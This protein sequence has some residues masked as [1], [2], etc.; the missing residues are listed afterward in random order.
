M[1][2]IGLPVDTWLPIEP[3]ICDGGFFPFSQHVRKKGFHDSQ[4][5]VCH[6]TVY[7][8]QTL[9]PAYWVYRTANIG[10]QSLFTR[11]IAGNLFI[12]WS[13]TENKHGFHL[14]HRFSQ[15]TMVMDYGLFQRPV[16]A[17]LWNMRLINPQDYVRSCGLVEMSASPVMPGAGATTSTGQ[18]HGGR[19]CWVL[20][21]PKNGWSKNG[22]FL[23][24]SQS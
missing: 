18:S 16:V 11:E 19:W 6:I 17:Q 21:P 12:C 4:L 7:W 23:F 9:R 2:L 10:S 20:G 24:W 1:E 14:H 15:E 8:V 3:M 13:K 22:S 5:Q